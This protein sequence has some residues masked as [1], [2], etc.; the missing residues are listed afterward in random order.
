MWKYL[1][2]H[3]VLTKILKYRAMRSCNGHTHVVPCTFQVQL[4]K[5]HN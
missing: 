2:T 5:L 4:E 3:R 1:V